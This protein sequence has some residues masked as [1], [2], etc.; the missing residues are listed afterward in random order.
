MVK[1]HKV[2][3]KFSYKKKFGIKIKFKNKS[4]LKLSALR[5]N[6]IFVSFD[7][8]CSNRYLLCKLKISKNVS[9][10]YTSQCTIS[11]TTHWFVI[12]ISSNRQLSEELFPVK[13]KSSKIFF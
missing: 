7:C 1:S 10:F 11:C 5:E 3:N 9:F 4:S 2:K 8:F 13:S 12:M 6:F